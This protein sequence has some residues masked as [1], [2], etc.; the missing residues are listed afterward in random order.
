MFSR[1]LA[2]CEKMLFSRVWS[3]ILKFMMAR[4]CLTPLKLKMGN[5][6]LDR[7]SLALRNFE[8]FW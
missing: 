1:G 4:N 8:E 2:E 7:W 3:K 5:K 6:L